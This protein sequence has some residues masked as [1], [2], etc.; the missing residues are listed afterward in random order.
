M[1]ASVSTMTLLDAHAAFEDARLSGDRSFERSAWIGFSVRG[2]GPSPLLG[3][4]SRPSLLVAMTDQGHDRFDLERTAAFD[5][6]YPS[7]PA[8]RAIVRFTRR[9]RDCDRTWDLCVHCHAGIWR[10]GAVA[11]WLVSTGVPESAMSH[12][13]SVRCESEPLPYNQTI[14]SLLQ[15]ADAEVLL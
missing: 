5:P 12:R 14:V 8:A 3:V 4:R 10:S 1:I 6:P 2:D 9:L 15:M 11:E 7:L 13:R